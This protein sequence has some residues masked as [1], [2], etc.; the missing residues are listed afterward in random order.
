[1]ENLSDLLVF[2]LGNFWTDLLR[3]LVNR[4]ILYL[5]IKVGR[6]GLHNFGMNNRSIRDKRLHILEHPLQH[7]F[8]FHNVFLRYDCKNIS[9]KALKLAKIP[10]FYFSNK[11]F[12]FLS[13]S[14]T[15]PCCFPSLK[16]LNNL[17]HLQYLAEKYYPTWTTMWFSKLSTTTVSFRNKTS[18]FKRKSRNCSKSLHPTMEMSINVGV[19]ECSDTSP[20]DRMMTTHV[21]DVMITSLTAQLFGGDANSATSMPVSRVKDIKKIHAHSAM[22]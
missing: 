2:L 20:R 7:I 12:N 11:N 9:P 4:C 3:I 1:M 5:Q 17:Y 18:F 14:F 8:I 22:F 21:I 15:L 6:E 19:A 10:L 13:R 16:T